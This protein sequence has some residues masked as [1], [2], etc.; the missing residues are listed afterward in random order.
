MGIRTASTLRHA[1][2]HGS[3]IDLAAGTR[4]GQVSGHLGWYTWLSARLTRIVSHAGSHGMAGMD[5]GVLW[6]AWV[7]TR[8]DARHHV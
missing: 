4:S 1:S 2:H 6:H 7:E 8:A 5:P 3:G